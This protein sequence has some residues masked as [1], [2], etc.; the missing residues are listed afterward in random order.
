MKNSD[1]FYSRAAEFQSKR[2]EIIDTYESTLAKLDKAKGSQLYTEETE[3]AAKTR[4]AALQALQNEYRDYFRISINAMSEANGKRG[5]A[6]P[7]ADQLAIL[8]ALKM[9]DNVSQKELDRAANSCKDNALAISVIN[10]IA[11][12]NGYLRG[13]NT[14]SGEMSIEDADKVIDDL[15][16]ALPDFMAHDTSRAARIA[17]EHNA[18]LYGAS[19]EER[20]LEKRPLFDSKASCFNTLL[21]FGMSA[22]R[23][24]GFIAAV[25]GE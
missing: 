10:E 22:E 25:D 13:Y 24:T 21:P 19:G 17:R 7:T 16:A 15:K 18:R 1:L 20:P 14:E 8:Q 23:Y 9:R 11:Q 5:I 12:K 2:K 3:K 4:D 6:A